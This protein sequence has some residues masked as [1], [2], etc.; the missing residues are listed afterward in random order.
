MIPILLIVLSLSNQP[1]VIEQIQF[2]TIKSCEIAVQKIEREL[3]YLNAHAI[4]IDRSIE[5]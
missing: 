1:P 2:R 4:C 3:S 5:N